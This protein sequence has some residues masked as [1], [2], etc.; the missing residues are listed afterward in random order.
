MKRVISNED[1]IV[2]TMEIDG[3]KTHITKSQ[4]ITA[5]LEFNKAMRNERG[6]KITDDCYNHVAMI[7]AI[8]QVKMLQDHDLNIFHMHDP[9]Q[10]KL[11]KRVMNSSEYSFLKTSDLNI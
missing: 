7:P 1:G 3:D 11:Y 10:Q 8:F 4:D 9:D 5:A 6:K 2:T